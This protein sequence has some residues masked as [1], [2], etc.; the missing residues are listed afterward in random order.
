MNE[1]GG[2]AGDRLC[3]VRGS[4]IRVLS[5]LFRDW[6]FA[7]ATSVDRVLRKHMNKVEDSPVKGESYNVDASKE[8]RE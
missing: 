2:S 1:R 8:E 7:E 4:V 5:S 3:K 6:Q